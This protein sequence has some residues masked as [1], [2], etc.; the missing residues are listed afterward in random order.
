MQ[1]FAMSELER[2][3]EAFKCHRC[4]LCCVDG[5]R[6]RVTN[7]DVN[8]IARH[9][10]QPISL[11]RAMHVTQDPIEKTVFYFKHFKPCEFYEP[12][13]HSCVIYA[14]RPRVCQY[15]PWAS[16][17]ASNKPILLPERCP[18]AVQSYLEQRLK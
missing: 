10:K 4:G 8:R 9:L 17:I 15:F 7:A 1:T 13:T 16:Q 5:T 2:L 6:I 14:V 3:Q 11:F 12:M 18:G